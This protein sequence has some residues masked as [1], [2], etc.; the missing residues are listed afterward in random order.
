MKQLY[1]KIRRLAKNRLITKPS[2]KESWADIL[3]RYKDLPDGEFIDEL[4][5]KYYS[6]RRKNTI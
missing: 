5:D 1:K 3:H 4:L 6:P 2:K